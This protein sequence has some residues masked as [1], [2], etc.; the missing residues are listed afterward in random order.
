MA[1]AMGKGAGEKPQPRDGAKEMLTTLLGRR[2]DLAVKPAL[3][4]LI[5]TGVLAEARLIYVASGE[6]AEI[7]KAESIE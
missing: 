6:V 4:P 2:A 1:Q 7:L 5:R 3:K